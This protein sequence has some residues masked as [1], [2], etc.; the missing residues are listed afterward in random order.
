MSMLLPA[1]VFSA[2]EVHKSLRVVPEPAAESPETS[3]ATWQPRW[4]T[5]GRLQLTQALYRLD[6]CLD[7]QPIT[8]QLL[9]N[10]DGSFAMSV[11][12]QGLVAC[13]TVPECQRLF[14]TAFP[15]ASQSD[16]WSETCLPLK[17]SLVRLDC[18]L[19]TCAGCAKHAYISGMGFHI[20]EQDIAPS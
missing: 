17:L 7:G 16:P 13:S 6:C 5:G 19:V 11:R 15:Q 18:L 10:Q 3:A 2:R 12:G 1:Q 14:A 4:R 20:H 9:P 8:C